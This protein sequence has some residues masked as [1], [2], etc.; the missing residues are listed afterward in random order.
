M[1]PTGLRQFM[2]RNA[3]GRQ[4]S[5]GGTRNQAAIRLAKTRN[6]LKANYHRLFESLPNPYL[7]LDRRL[8]IITA[9]RAYLEIVRLAL[10]DIVGRW[11]WDAAV[12]RGVVRCLRV[13]WC[14]LL[15]VRRRW[16]LGSRVAP[17]LVGAWNRR[18]DGGWRVRWLL[19]W[20]VGCAVAWRPA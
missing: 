9:N 6:V 18:L 13:D 11:A 15:A 14:R 20:V 10:P 1:I 16:R 12:G 3:S 19:V 2:Q 17:L 8:H 4:T 5:G 7:V